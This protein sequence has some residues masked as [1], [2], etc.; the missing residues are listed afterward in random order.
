MRKFYIII[1]ILYGGNK[2]VAYLCKNW[3]LAVISWNL[4]TNFWRITS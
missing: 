3:R 4:P 2:N 1:S